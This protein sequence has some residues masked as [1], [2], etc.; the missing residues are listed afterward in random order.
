MTFLGPEDFVS[1]FGYLDRRK[2]I[3][4][5]LE[6]DVGNGDITSEVLIPEDL[7]AEAEVWYKGTTES[8]VVCGIQEAC[9][10]LEI[11]DC[12]TTKLV[13]DGAVLTNDQPVIAIKGSA[14]GILKAERTALN[15]LMRMSGIA[16]ECRK[17]N[18]QLRNLGVNTLVTATRKTSPG[19]RLFDKKAIV[20]GGGNPHRMGL[21][22]RILIKDN[23][24][25]IMGNASECIATAR[26]HAGSNQKIECEVRSTDELLSVVRAGADTVMLDNFSTDNAK[27]AMCKLR[28]LGLRNH[29]LVEISGGINESNFRDFADL[30]PDFISVGSI[31]HSTK[32]VDFSMTVKS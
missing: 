24:I 22:D 27:E 4:S 8:A 21:Y 7:S 6:E 12:S 20:V 29:V 31:T 30:N 26:K 18:S 1:L 9:T 3:L 25:A 11:C 28:D 32:A 10:V 23:H 14:R 2:Q 15:L 13:E 19:M 17:Y 16:T 5:F